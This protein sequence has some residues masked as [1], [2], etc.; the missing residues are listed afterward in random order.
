MKWLSYVPGTPAWRRRKD[1]L[2]CMRTAERVQE[3]VDGELPAGA[4]NHELLRHLDACRRCGGEA[5]AFREL[6]EAIGR[7]GR[8]ADPDLV[9]RLER[10]CHRLDELD[11]E[12]E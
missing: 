8:T 1:M 11:V 7:V 12:S 2:L 4:T 6:K 10:L 9:E 3:I 5:E